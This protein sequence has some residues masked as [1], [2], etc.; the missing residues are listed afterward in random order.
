[1]VIFALPMNFL[2]D[3]VPT[4]WYI[5]VNVY[6]FIVVIVNHQ[7]Y[8]DF[9]PMPYSFYEY[10]WRAWAYF[11]LFYIFTLFLITIIQLVSACCVFDLPMLLIGDICYYFGCCIS[12][13]S[14]ILVCIV[15]GLR[16]IAPGQANFVCIVRSC[17]ILYCIYH[18]LHVVLSWAIA[19][20]WLYVIQYLIQIMCNH[21]I[22]IY[23][24]LVSQSIVCFMLL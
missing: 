10:R 22:Y 15:V 11:C 16:I 17:I 20:G 18:P 14:I 21:N 7:I 24:F 4:K 9:F 13:K 19:L 6:Q 1:M 5:K 2:L 23:W 8:L 12:A 3:M